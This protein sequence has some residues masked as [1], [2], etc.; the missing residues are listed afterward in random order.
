MKV[1][2]KKFA[3]RLILGSILLLLSVLGINLIVDPYSMTSYNLLGIPNKYAR[4][5]RAEKVAKLYKDPKYDNMLFGSSRVYVTNPYM[6]DKYL[7]GKTYN[8]GVGT[9]LIEDQLGFLLFLQRIHKLPKNAIFGLDFYSFNPTVPTNK[10]FLKNNDLNFLQKKAGSSIYFE[11]FFSIDALR[12]SYKTLY[13]FLYKHVDYKRFAPRGEAT[14]V[15]GIM[16]YYPKNLE[17]KKFPRELILQ[18]KHKIQTLHYT[19]VSRER[20]GYVRKIK[21]VCQ[22][23]NIN[24][25]FFTTPLNGQMLDEFLSNPQ[26]AKSMQEFKR[27]LAKITPYYDFLTHNEIVDNS[28]YFIDT[29]HFIPQAGN[30]L[31]AR[32]FGDENVTLPENFGVFVSQN[33]E[34]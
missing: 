19:S 4:D 5:D 12:A 21:E 26:Q 10:Y 33:L 15:G 24:C 29:M 22:E 7:G 34:E 27:E 28:F 1:Q 20:L 25:I 6:V 8:C 3:K 17:I 32:I 16:E 18:D 31:Y 2:F 23:N 9:A 30:L 13:N 11:K 14:G